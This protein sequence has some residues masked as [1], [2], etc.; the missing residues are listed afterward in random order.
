M[1]ENAAPA[2]EVIPEGQ[3]AA[4]HM[5]PKS[6]F[7]EVNNAKKSLEQRLGVIEAERETARQEALKKAG[8]FTTLE[9]EL[10]GKLT[11]AEARAAAA[12]EKAAKYEAQQTAIREATI[13]QLPEAHRGIASAL[14]P[15]KLAE[16][17]TLHGRGGPI[18]KPGEPGTGGGAG[19]AS[20]EEIRA[21]AGK[22]G[23]LK[24]NFG[25]L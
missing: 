20:Q 10:K 11:A 3:P 13:A 5:I 19:K 24:A 22:P 9:T 1:P 16:Y 7:D 2:T 12:E 21:N 8:D 6:R 23:W 18:I 14:P 25:R 17:A 15:D 4:G